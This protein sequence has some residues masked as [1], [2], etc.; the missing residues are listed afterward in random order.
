MITGWTEESEPDDSKPGVRTYVR[1][2]IFLR[3][4]P[5]LF[6]DFKNKLAELDINQTD[7][8]SN[9]IKFY[10]EFLDKNSIVVPKIHH[11]SVLPDTTMY[12]PRAVWLHSADKINARLYE[13]EQG[14]RELR[15]CHDKGVG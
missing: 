6:D 10:L 7:F 3:L 4:S 14:L 1:S 8:V 9:A 12:T 11:P 15:E 5:S 2:Q 13:L